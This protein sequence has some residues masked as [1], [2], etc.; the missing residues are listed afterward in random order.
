MTPAKKGGG[1]RVLDGKFVA[2][3]R[4]AVGAVEAELAEYL[5]LSGAHE[6]DFYTLFK[7]P[8]G[9]TSVTYKDAGRLAFNTICMLCTLSELAHVGELLAHIIHLR[10]AEVRRKQHLRNRFEPGTP[11]HR[12]EV[13]ITTRHLQTLAMFVIAS[14]TAAYIFRL[15]NH[16]PAATNPNPLNVDYSALAGVAS[17]LD[18]FFFLTTAP[19]DR[20]RRVETYDEFKQNL[21][22]LP[23]TEFKRASTRKKGSERTSSHSDET[24]K[25]D[26]LEKQLYSKML[27]LNLSDKENEG[28]RP[29]MSSSVT[30][31]PSA[32]Q[33]AARMPLSKRG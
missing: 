2:E 32:S 18:L 30:P 12:V 26:R 29:N 1:V 28:A 6:R 3:G 8:G 27:Q 19:A 7:N 9:I 11:E 16:E 4:S 21:R 24:R 10:T 23:R 25:Q 33:S 5:N 20:R 13:D 22:R 17:P 15:R 31:R 14:K